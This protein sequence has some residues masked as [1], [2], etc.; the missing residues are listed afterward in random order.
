MQALSL[1]RA[2][3]NKPRCRE[4][5]GYRLESLAVE[6]KETRCFV[7]TESGQSLLSEQMAERLS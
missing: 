3:K 4:V 1:I 5:Q 6:L 2:E 7:E